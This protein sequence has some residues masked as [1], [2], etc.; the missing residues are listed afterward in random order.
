V[1]HVV[2]PELRRAVKTLAAFAAGAWVLRTSFLEASAH[3]H[4]L[5]EPVRGLACRRCA[6]L[7]DAV[8]GMLLTSLTAASAAG[9]GHSLHEGW[10]DASACSSSVQDRVGV[11]VARVSMREAGGPARVAREHH[12]Y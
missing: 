6:A 12:M 4:M 3:A 9:A 8:H 10:S 2:T 5:V 11:R 7:C 1:T